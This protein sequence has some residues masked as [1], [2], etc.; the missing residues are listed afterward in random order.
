MPRGVCLR[1]VGGRVSAGLPARLVL[2]QRSDLQRQDGSLRSAPGNASPH[3]R[4]LHLER[5]MYL[6]PM[7]ARARHVRNNLLDRRCLHARLHRRGLPDR[8][9]LRRF[10]IRRGILHR[11]VRG[12]QRLPDRLC[13]RHGG[14]RVSA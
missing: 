13:L 11:Q 14:W 8:I 5:G 6:G 2:R 4:V 10:R 3:R 9:N 7:H 1:H 12:H